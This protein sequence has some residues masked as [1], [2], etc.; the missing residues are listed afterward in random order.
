MKKEIEVWRV[1][2]F[3]YGLLFIRPLEC[4]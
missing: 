3:R 1:I 2:V 4:E